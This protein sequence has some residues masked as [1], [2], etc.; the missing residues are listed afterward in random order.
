MSVF[1]RQILQ[2]VI[3]KVRMVGG[4]IITGNVVGIPEITDPLA[5]HAR[6]LF[7]S[8]KIEGHKHRLARSDKLAQ[9]SSAALLLFQIIEKYCVS[10][11]LKL[12]CHLMGEVG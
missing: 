1:F 2:P 5:V 11:F 12:P 8:L 10:Q 9:L 3:V 4:N 6:L 7:Q